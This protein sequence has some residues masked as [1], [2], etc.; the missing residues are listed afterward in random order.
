MYQWPT[1]S[2]STQTNEFVVACQRLASFKKRPAIM[3]STCFK[4]SSVNEK[5]WR[6]NPLISNRHVVYLLA[7]LHTWRDGDRSAVT[8][9]FLKKEVT[10]IFLKLLCSKHYLNL[11]QLIITF[12]CFTQQFK[13]VKH[14]LSVTGG[15]FSIES[16]CW[17][18][19]QK[20]SSSCA[21]PKQL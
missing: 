6:K 2:V 9:E 5:T 7:V 14:S 3:S 21:Q 12:W 11:N 4:L 15:L 1:L 17:I 20:V 19:C 10:Y 18:W 13:A 8:L 16:K